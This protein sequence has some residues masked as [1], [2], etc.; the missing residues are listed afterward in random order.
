MTARLTDKEILKAIEETWE[1]SDY[2]A[3]L[4]I[5]PNDRAIADAQLRKAKPVFKQEGRREVVEWLNENVRH[6]GTP[7]QSTKVEF[8]GLVVWITDGEWQAQKK[9]W[10]IG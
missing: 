3:P 9:E 5:E 2:G 8:T 7:L 6:I 10:G 1:G 4:E